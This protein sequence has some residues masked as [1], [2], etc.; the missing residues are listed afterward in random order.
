MMVILMNKEKA[1][2]DKKQ[3]KHKEDLR[4]VENSVHSK[5]KH[6]HGGKGKGRLEDHFDEMLETGPQLFRGQ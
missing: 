2:E 4:G 1:K 6:K 5:G 3:H